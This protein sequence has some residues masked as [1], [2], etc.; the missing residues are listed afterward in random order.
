MK[1]RFLTRQKPQLHEYAASIIIRLVRYAP[2]SLFD[3]HVIADRLH[4][5][6]TDRHGGVGR[7]AHPHDRCGRFAKEL[8]VAGADWVGTSPR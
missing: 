1:R 5:S 3:L 2:R 8:A 7:N 4:F 6:D